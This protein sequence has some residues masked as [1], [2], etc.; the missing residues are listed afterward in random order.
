MCDIGAFGKI[1]HKGSILPV[2]ISVLFFILH[3][4][5]FIHFVHNITSFYD[6]YI[7][8]ENKKTILM[9]TGVEFSLNNRLEGCTIQNINL[10]MLIDNML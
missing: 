10:L 9:M 5:I 6:K 7:S 8:L 3:K 4:K 2:H 1:L